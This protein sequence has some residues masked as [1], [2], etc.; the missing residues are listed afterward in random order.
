MVSDEEI[1]AEMKAGEERR[2]AAKEAMIAAKRE[3]EEAV[4]A[5]KAAFEER[6]NAARE[7]AEARRRKKQEEEEEKER[8]SKPVEHQGK[9]Q[10]ELTDEH[11][12][13]YKTN[14]P[15]NSQQKSAMHDVAETAIEEHESAKE[16]DYLSHVARTKEIDEKRRA[17]E[18]KANPRTPAFET[19][20]KREQAMEQ[21]ARQSF[22]PVENEVV[23]TTI[24]EASSLGKSRTHVPA[25]P[26][27]SRTSSPIF[28][29]KAVE[30]A[31][32]PFVPTARKDAAI[33]N[34]KNAAMGNKAPQQHTPHPYGG[35]DPFAQ[36]NAESEKTKKEMDE[37]G[38]NAWQGDIDVNAFTNQPQRAK[39]NQESINKEMRADYAAGSSRGTMGVLKDI[40]TH[41]HDTAQEIG[42]AVEKKVAQ[43]GMERKQVVMDAAAKRLEPEYRANDQKLHEGK[44]SKEMHEIRNKQLDQKFER[45]STPIEQRV[46]GAASKEATG[47]FMMAAG[48]KKEAAQAKHGNTIVGAFARGLESTQHKMEESQKHPV[49]PRILKYGATAPPDPKTF[50]GGKGTK[51]QSPT[52][53]TVVSKG[54]NPGINFG[55]A[56]GFGS[57]L[58]FGDTI[59]RSPAFAG[60]LF[61]RGQPTPAPAPAPR[62]AARRKR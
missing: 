56:G 35:G 3:R 59:S 34:F 57:P 32:E 21:T 17:A 16:I 15:A 29:N 6:A 37:R 54:K 52:K 41:P 2:A 19:K 28:E 44:I 9:S 53:G 4:A 45:L 23:T 50:G 49:V 46:A 51:K 39:A 27:I 38:A 60:N 33:E 47:L 20:Y 58:T 14:P 31:R 42:Y 22:E 10:K 24:I 5:E 12:S 7:L 55:G 11:Y 48:T 13:Q 43:R 61:G 40:L 26:P 1:S 8:A 25:N 30:K 36:M 62:R 18:R